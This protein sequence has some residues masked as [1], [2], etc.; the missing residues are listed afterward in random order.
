MKLLGIIGKPLSNSLSPKIFNAIFKKCRLLHRYLSFQV[1]KAYLKNLILCMKLTGVEGLNVT[2]PYKEAILPHLDLLDA[3]ARRAGA[4]NIIYRKGKKF[5]GGNTDG[6]GFCKALGSKFKWKPAGKT[7]TLIGA[8]GAARGLACSLSAA[9]AKKIQIL[10]RHPQRAKR[11]A[12]FFKKQFPKTEWVSAPLT[13]SAMR[14][15]FFATDLL[16]QTTPV[17]RKLPI[18]ALPSHAIVSDIVTHPK[19]TPLLRQA[20]GKH[21]K[22]MDGRRMLL[23]QAA[24]NLKIW[25][26]EY[27]KMGNFLRTVGRF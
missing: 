12:S 16:V 17:S 9:G 24:L 27:L 15:S 10:N 4:V 3:S 22:T 1:E 5:V 13:K 20:K 7:I 11:L 6:E 8:G 23:F 26:G 19:I 25:T 14:Q 18:A 21:F 2:A